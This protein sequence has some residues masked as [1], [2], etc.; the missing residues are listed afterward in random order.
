MGVGH[1]Q[2]VCG[3]QRTTLGGASFYIYVVLE[4]KLWPVGLSGRC[5]Y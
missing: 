4:L 5:F 3:G 1:L 2:C